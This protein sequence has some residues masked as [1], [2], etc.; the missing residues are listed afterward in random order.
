L[1]ALW[2]LPVTVLAASA[3]GV[4]PTLAALPD[5]VQVGTRVEVK[6]RLV[7]PRA[8]V[9][10]LVEIDTRPG[11]DD[12]LGGVIESVDAPAK[13]LT[14]AGIRIVT[15]DGTVLEGESRQPVVFGDFK[16]GQWI[17]VDGELGEDG[18]LK[19]SEVHIKTAKPERTGQTKLEGR[20][21]RMDTARNTF[22]LLGTTVTVTPRTQI[23]R[24]TGGRGGS[25]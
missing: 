22:T 5:D 25:E 16:R 8:L 17:S 20:V 3:F 10:E 13:A 15:S 4:A 21:Q 11:G 2:F 9:A 14:A 18:S 12:G 19:A 23:T 6:G 24:K 1:A 7:G